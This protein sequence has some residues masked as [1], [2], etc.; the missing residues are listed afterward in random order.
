MPTNQR[1]SRSEGVFQRS[2][3]ADSVGI[4]FEQFGYHSCTPDFLPV[5][6]VGGWHERQQRY[7][8]VWYRYREEPFGK[9]NSIL[10]LRITTAHGSLVVLSYT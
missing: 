8:T 3:L 5:L 4:D 9:L 10:F 6:L 1:S 2:P 7:T